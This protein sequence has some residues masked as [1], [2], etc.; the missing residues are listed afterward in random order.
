M[1]HCSR[2]GESNSDNALSCRKC[3]ARMGAKDP[4]LALL[5][6]V[7][8]TGLGQLYNRQY[9]KGLICLSFYM[10]GAFLSFVTILEVYME[11][12]HS[13]SISLYDLMDTA[14]FVPV[15]AWNLGNEEPWAWFMLAT[16]LITSFLWIWG[17]TDAYNAANRTAHLPD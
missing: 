14:P 9:F 16:P 10:T 5:L 6:S 2:C 3:R 17:M 4:R 8:A 13:G 11:L 1:L 7:L 12:S 15:W